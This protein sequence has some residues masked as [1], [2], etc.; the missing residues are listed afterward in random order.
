MC[1]VCAYS[2]SE[3]FDVFSTDMRRVSVIG[4]PCISK[5]QSKHRV[6]KW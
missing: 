5:K 2:V 1:K 3:N 4:I 6:T